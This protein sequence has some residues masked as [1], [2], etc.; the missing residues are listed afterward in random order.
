M[1]RRF[2]SSLVSAPT[3]LLVG[4]LVYLPFS[5]QLPLIRGEGMYA[6]I[7]KE[8]LAAGSWLTPILNGA[9]YLDKPQL[10][11]W[12]NLA[13]YKVLG[14]SAWAVRLVTLVLT[15][16]EILLAYLIGR[17]LFTLRAAWLGGFIL[18]S[19]LGFFVLHHQILTDHLVTVALAASFYFLLRWQQSP[20]FRW[21][22]LFHLALVVG[23][24]S[25]GFIGVLFPL[26]IGG[27]YAWQ[28][29]LPQLSRLFCSPRGLGL[30]SLLIIPW[31]IGVEQA[32]P[33]FLKHQII[34]EQVMRFLGQRQPMDINPF[35][36]WEF[37]LFAAIWL[38]PW[39]LLLPEALYRFWQDTRP[40]GRA[41]PRARLLLIWAGVVMAFFTLSASRIEYYSLPALLPL[42]LVLGWRVD[43]FLSGTQDRSFSWALG[44]L[45]LLGVANL[46][47]VPYMEHLCA[48]NRREFAGIFL[49][50]RPICY[51]VAVL[52]PVLALLGAAAGWRR[53]RLALAS[54]SALALALVY[55]SFQ[56]LFLL[57]PILG[58][59]D[60]GEFI[61]AQAGP[62]D[63]VVMEYIEEFEY[64][65]SLA[66][67][68]DRHILMV[69]REGLP[70]FPYPVAPQENY[71]I[72]PEHLGELWQGPHRVFLLTDQCVPRE[73]FLAGARV[74]LA[75]PGKCLLVNR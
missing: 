71:L 48:T 38:L 49:L 1:N 7:P 3:L 45:A 9:H 14:V 61:R 75:L 52:V 72:S 63:L 39:V 54:L 25:K 29:R 18:L 65:A 2:L 35:S 11:Y 16:T 41:D 56:C 57:S 60:P 36:V 23:F 28:Q 73:P 17:R 32:N 62:E 46:F 47:L 69:Q 21:A 5:L 44:L 10:L 59:R 19:S 33:G 15:L 6:L 31:F 34:N 70:Q 74:A 64:G 50:F 37:W 53:P 67:Y 24:F 8:M 20:R 42:A 43:R 55:F 26:L 12:L 40:S 27:L 13:A 51:Q 4:L 58:D 66:F 30:L 22:V 68:A